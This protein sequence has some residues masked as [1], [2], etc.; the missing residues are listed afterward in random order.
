MPS[1]EKNTRIE[2][3][4]LEVN[5]TSPKIVKNGEKNRQNKIL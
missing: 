5:C 1:L 4:T 3:S 2:S